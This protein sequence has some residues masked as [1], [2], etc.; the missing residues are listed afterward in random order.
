LDWEFV[1][2]LILQT[3]TQYSVSTGN[4]KVVNK[5]KSYA[6]GPYHAIVIIHTGQVLIKDGRIFVCGK[7]IVA[8][9][10]IPPRIFPQSILYSPLLLP[11]ILINN[12]RVV[13][14]Y[15]GSYHSGC[16]TAQGELYVWG[17]NNNGQCALSNNSSSVLK[18][19]TLVITKDGDVSYVSAPLNV[20]ELIQKKKKK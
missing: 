10:G 6:C 13:C 5:V 11:Q 15:A 8:Q 19:H 18:H 7:N 14:V 17:M 12:K 1:P 20:N 9:L 2:G 16:L 3:A 4:V